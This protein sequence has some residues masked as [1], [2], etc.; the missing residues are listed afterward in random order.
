MRHPDLDLHEL[1]E[2]APDDGL[3]RFA[4]QRALLLDAA[5]V[6]LMRRYVAQSFS[7]AAAK[8]VFARFGYAQGWRLAD[9]LRTAVTWDDEAD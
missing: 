2:L 9:T 8:D 5:A 1:L 3:I 6:G 4:G 7:P